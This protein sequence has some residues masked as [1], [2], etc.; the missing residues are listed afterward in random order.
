LNQIQRQRKRDFEK[1][2]GPL[3]IWHLLPFMKIKEFKEKIFYVIHKVY[4]NIEYIFEY[5]FSFIFNY[6]DKYIQ[7]FYPS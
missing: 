5:H 2:F 1:T 4:T 3:S 7:R 6:T